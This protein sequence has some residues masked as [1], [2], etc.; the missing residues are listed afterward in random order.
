MNLD[1][2]VFLIECMD[3]NDNPVD[4]SLVVEA[5]AT[6]WKIENDELEEKYKD[7]ELYS[8]SM[9]EALQI[10]SEV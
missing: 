5:T 6:V 4:I 9:E 7:L 1:E 10:F 2:W 8:L 3:S